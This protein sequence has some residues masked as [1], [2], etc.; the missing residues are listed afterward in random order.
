MIRVEVEYDSRPVLP[1]PI[2]SF[3]SIPSLPPSL[4]PLPLLFRMKQGTSVWQKFK[5]DHHRI[6]YLE[7]VFV[8]FRFEVDENNFDRWPF[9]SFYEDFARGTFPRNSEIL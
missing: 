7:F 2:L 3:F 8:Y 9:V 1:P 4:P 6:V 5:L